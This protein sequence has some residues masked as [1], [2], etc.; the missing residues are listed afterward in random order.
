MLPASSH[1]LSLSTHHSPTLA[2]Q[3]TIQRWLVAPPCPHLLHVCAA[4]FVQRLAVLVEL[5]IEFE[6]ELRLSSGL[7]GAARFEL[8][9]LFLFC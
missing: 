9:L 2:Q 1:S 5:V 6:L 7:W 4:V 3:Q 8:A